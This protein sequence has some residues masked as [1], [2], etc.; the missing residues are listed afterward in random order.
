MLLTVTSTASPAT[1]LGFLLHKHPD[2]VQNFD[3]PFG[4]AVGYYPEADEQRCTFALQVDID[5]IALLKR[6]GRQLHPATI[7]GYVNDRPYAA[8]S[9]LAVAIGRVLSTALRGRCD[10]RPELVSQPLP[11]TVRVPALAA[12]ASS[13]DDGGPELIERLFGPLGWRVDVEVEPYPVPEWDD[14]PYVTLT[15]SGEQRLSDALSHLYV[16]LPVLDGSKHYFVSPDEVDKLIRRSEGWLA[17][18]PERD[19]I[20]RRYLRRANWV[21]D[22][23]ARLNAVDDI[24]LDEP[25]DTDDAPTPL[26]QQRLDAVLGV[27]R[28][29]GARSIADV[30]CGEGVYLR[31][32]LDDPTF[33]RILGVDVSARELDRA[34]RKLNL[35]RRSDTQRERIRLRQSSV[36]Y[37]D[38]ELVGFDALLLVEV[39]EHVEPNRLDSLAANVFSHARPRHVVATTPNAEYNAIYGLAPGELRHPDHRFEWTRAEFRAWTAAVAQR[40]GYAVEFR[41]VG[42][43]DEK[44]GP[45]TQL[46][47]FTCLDGASS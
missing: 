24:E 7:A 20:T 31:A 4:R 15:L 10:A 29:V 38:D 3:L 33:T 26:K 1:D 45:P 43:P 8:G 16:L 13:V 46:A 9:M 18:H 47:L 27:L 41:D 25:A 44:L 5:P 36:T 19:L 40:H 11:L 12:R 37:R 17:T 39:V 34:E 30:G 2:R 22:A 21:D 14:S 42:V 32:L 23:L 35:D 28:E 6:R